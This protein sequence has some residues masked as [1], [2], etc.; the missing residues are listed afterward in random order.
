MKPKVKNEIILF[1]RNFILF[2]MNTVFFLREREIF[3]DP[4]FFEKIIFL[5]VNLF[6]NN[7]NFP[8]PF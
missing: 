3:F 6:Y 8:K 7:L 5:Y 1:G 2:L 4:I